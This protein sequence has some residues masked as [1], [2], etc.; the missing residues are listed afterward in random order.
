M[1]VRHAGLDELAELELLAAFADLD[2]AQL[3]GPVVDIL[4]QVPMDRARNDVPE[5]GH[6]ATNTIR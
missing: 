3:A 5:R 6:P 2:R 4:K 1:D